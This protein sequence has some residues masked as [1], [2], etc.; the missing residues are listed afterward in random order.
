MLP[1]PSKTWW[2]VYGLVDNTEPTNIRYI[3]VTVNPRKRLSDHISEARSGRGDKTNSHKCRWIRKVLES[4]GSVHMIV[5]AQF[6]DSASAY[7]EEKILV[8]VNS[9]NLTN[10]AEGG[11]GGLT[12]TDPALKSALYRKIK[13]SYTE[14][15]RAL[16][17]KRISAMWDDED[18][19]ERET[20]RRRD[21]W[22][23]EEYRRAQKEGLKEAQQQTDYLGKAARGRASS[24]KWA[25]GSQR[26]ADT[27][28]LPENRE[29]SRGHAQKN[30][31]SLC[32]EQRKNRAFKALRTRY[33]NIAR[34]RG[35]VLELTEIPHENH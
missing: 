10:K 32:P 9:K 20:Q 29:I 31:D 24:K 11:I 30:W 5:L 26:M 28:R 6:S 33:Y 8:S 1:E 21:Q 22:N 35:Y 4:Q 16:T 23:S 27:S 34:S 19:R 12:V 15:K 7:R 3:G 17:G 14:E 2:Y 25:E 13:D 18:Y